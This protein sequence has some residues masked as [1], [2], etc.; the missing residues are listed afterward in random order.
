MDLRELL[1]TRD[2]R[3]I[4]EIMT[5]PVVAAEQDD[6]QEDLAQ[7]FA[8]YQYRMLPV[9]DTQDHLLGVIRYKDIMKPAALTAGG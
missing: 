7:M 6:T 4:E 1:L 2:D 9:V 8:K 5:A 3:L